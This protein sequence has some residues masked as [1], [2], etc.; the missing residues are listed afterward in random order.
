MSWQRERGPV[1]VMPGHAEDRCT[2][3]LITQLLFI[4]LRLL[5]LHSEP[6]VPKPTCDANHPAMPY[7]I[8]THLVS[9]PN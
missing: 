6:A 2:S 1:S 8:C 3:F 4:S 5:Q 9:I 7:Q